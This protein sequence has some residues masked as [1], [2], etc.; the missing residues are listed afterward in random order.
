MIGLGEIT[1]IL[2]SDGVLKACKTGWSHVGYVI[3]YKKNI[4]KLEDEIIGL[5]DEWRRIDG[6]AHRAR[7]DARVVE[8]DVR[9]WLLS[10]YGMK[11]EVEVFLL[12]MVRENKWCFKCSCPNIY[13]RYWL[14]KESEKKTARV[15]RLKE[16]GTKFM[17]CPM[18]HRAPLPDSGFTFSAKYE[19][20]DSR[21][22]IFEEIMKTLEDPS[23]KMIGIYGPG[24]VGKTT[25]VEEVLQLAKR[26][27]LFDSVA[28]TT[29]SKVVEKEKVQGEL[30]SQLGLTL[31][32]FGRAGKLL[33]RLSNGGKNLVILDDVWEPLDLAE[34]GIPTTDGGNNEPLIDLP[35]IGIPFTYGSNMVCK[36]VITSRKQRVC[37]MM[38]KSNE[39]KVFPIEVL[40]DT[41][42]W[43]LFTKM[44]EISV[45]S[46]IPPAAEDV[47]NECG[48]L[49]VAICAVAAALKGKNNYAWI[50][51]HTQLKNSKLRAIVD[52][53]PK[54][55]SSL[56]LSYDFLE[57]KDAR[58]CFM[59][60]SL[61]YEDAEISIEDLVRY[62][63]GMRLLDQIHLN[64]VEDIRAR[65]LTLV[66]G[67]KS[68][69]LLLDGRSQN[70]VKMHDVIRDVAISIAEDEKGYLVNHDIKKWPEKGTYEHYSAMSLR[71]TTNICELPNELECRGLHTLVLKSN[72]DCSR[73]DVPNNFFNGMDNNLEVLDLTEIPL[74]SLPSSLPT[75]VKLRMLC[76]NGRLKIDIGLALLGR[77]RTLRYLA[78]KI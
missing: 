23:I 14:G 21:K 18:S 54:L 30:A 39:L 77:L 1:K 48:R 61:F 15:I 19:A 50:D 32:E 66:D 33:N 3:H 57:P 4:Q 63:I 65:V 76:L 53:D 59:L 52:V 12:D 16:E 62:S 56:K 45:N 36:V 38:Q 46:G 73:T 78:F 41:E 51:A 8:N 60:C 71:F 28:M 35:E 17:T 69:C 64:T 67:L 13:W 26:N 72:H 5:E 27:R 34:I 74:E 37:Q 44:A 47:C 2:C 11:A 9:Q 58:S 22:R 7:D 68:S 75:L 42:A 49:P 31:D 6:S 10:A 55:F 70:R 43:S 24:G 20:F 29:V 25:M 40:T